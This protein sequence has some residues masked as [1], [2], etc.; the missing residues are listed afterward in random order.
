M[1]MNGRLHFEKDS[2]TRLNEDNELIFDD[3]DRAELFVVE[4][5]FKWSEDFFDCGGETSEGY[6]SDPLSIL[7]RR[8]EC[9]YT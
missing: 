5:D 9:Q 4:G 1:A 7:E 2:H 6:M 3:K 8:E